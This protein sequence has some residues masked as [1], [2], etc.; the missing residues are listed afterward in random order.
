MAGKMERRRYS[1][2]RTKFE[3]LYSAGQEEG[4]GVLSDI[5]Y[6]GALVEETLLRPAVG[7]RVRLYVFLQPVFPF[8]I[9]GDVVRHTHDGFALEYKLVDPEV[10]QLVDEA[11][12]IVA[13]S[14]D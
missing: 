2:V 14:Q 8:E 9:I 13:R 1:R 6:S 11:A 3:L 10:R 5:S 12:A 7:T 4:T